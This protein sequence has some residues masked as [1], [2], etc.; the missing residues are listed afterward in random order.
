M[1]GLNNK[2]TADGRLK[3]T[4][5]DVWFRLV[6]SGKRSIRGQVSGQGL[7]LTHRRIFKSYTISIG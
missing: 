1:I 7:Y 3:Y 6:I 2:A 5:A 4:M